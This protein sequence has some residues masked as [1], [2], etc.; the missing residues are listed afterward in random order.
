MT[1]AAQA[2]PVTAPA[3][4]PPPNPVSRATALPAPVIRWLQ[5]ARPERWVVPG[6][7][8]LEGSARFKRGRLPYLPLDI[9]IWTRPGFDRVS[10]LEVRIAGVTLLRG[11]DAFVDGRGF[12]QVG[13]EL[14][15][16]P[17]V[18]QGSFHVMFLETLLVPGAWPAN[19][20][21]EPVDAGSARV[22]A[23]FAGG[24][25]HALVSFDPETGLPASYR[26]D[27]YRTA[28]E[29]KVPWTGSLAEWRDFGTLYY[30]SL[31]E[32]RWADQAQPWLK[33][34]I[35]RARIN[36]PMDVPLERAR[37]LLGGGVD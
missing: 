2:R 5:A 24:L 37:R 15:I 30:P 12:T 28:G 7:F 10:E 25:E 22:I 29:G 4:V 32:A 34:R 16:G 23:P 6:T 8:Y 31:I 14:S 33:M 20:R 17:S 26:T 18:D 19:I 13:S 11:L 27:R 35:A 9:R 3:V 36:V 21:W 1:I